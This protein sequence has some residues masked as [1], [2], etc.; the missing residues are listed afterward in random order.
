[1]KILIDTHIAL[2]AMA[3]PEKLPKEILSK[4][5]DLNNTIHVSI[6]SVWEV[7]IKN[8]KNKN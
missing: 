8:I 7:A 4:L 3:R 1:M 6:V 5:K 2:W